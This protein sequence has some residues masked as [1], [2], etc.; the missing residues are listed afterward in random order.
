[1]FIYIIVI[2]KKKKKKKK[3]KKGFLHVY[4]HSFTMVLCYVELVGRVSIVSHNPLLNL[5]LIILQNKC[6]I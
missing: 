3:K 6:Y 4:H 1:M 5:L 2:V